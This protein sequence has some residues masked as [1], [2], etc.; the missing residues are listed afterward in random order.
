MSLSQ[1]PLTGAGVRVFPHRG[2]KTRT[3]SW[4]ARGVWAVRPPG[5][6]PSGPVAAGWVDGVAEAVAP[7]PVGAQAVMSVAA[8]AEAASNV[9]AEELMGIRPASPG[10]FRSPYL[11]FSN[12]AAVPSTTQGY[13]HTDE[14]GSYRLLMNPWWTS[15]SMKHVLISQNPGEPFFSR[16]ACS[17]LVR[18]SPNFRACFLMAS[19]AASGLRAKTAWT[20]GRC[21][22]AGCIHQCSGP[23]A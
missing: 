13:T 20:I 5:E 9:V 19:A 1:N 3:A 16:N 14:T 15:R 22:P 11:D 21:I 7:S 2:L 6:A 12:S 18:F 23:T 8:W 10:F 17:I 4:T